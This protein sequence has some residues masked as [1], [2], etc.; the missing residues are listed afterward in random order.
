MNENRT[1][2]ATKV[3]TGPKCRFSYCH[4]WE[5]QS[6]NGE[7]PRYSVCV[8]IPKTDTETAGKIRAAIKAAYREGEAK[9]KG[10]ESLPP[11][12]SLKTPLRDGDVERP[13]DPAYAGCWFLNANSDRAPG[14]VD[15]H[16]QP[17]RDRNEVY[18][19]CYG[20]VSVTFFAFN[21]NG[22]R[23]IACGLN[24][25]QKVRDGEPL[26]GRMS[27]EEEFAGLEEDEEEEFPV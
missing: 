17:I 26:D 1:I 22:N 6:V 7:D 5:P 14:V 16:V 10:K 27:A 13:D 19:G 24:N 2:P 9:L 15:A 11:L 21:T 18:S 3:I 20:R 12:K 4:I 25:L 23:G 8:L